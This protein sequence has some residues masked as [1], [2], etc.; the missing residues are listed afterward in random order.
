[1]NEEQVLTEEEKFAQFIDQVE[2]ANRPKEEKPA[3]VTEAAD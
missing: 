1:M 2:E 3:E